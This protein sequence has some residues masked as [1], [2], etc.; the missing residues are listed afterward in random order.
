M[1][2]P[3]RILRPHDSNACLAVIAS[4]FKRGQVALVGWTLVAWTL[5]ATISVAQTPA[6]TS[7]SAPVD[8][9]TP[10]IITRQLKSL[11]WDFSRTDDANFNNRPDNWKRYE[12]IGYPS[13]VGWTIAARD[14]ALEKQMLGIDASLV[15]QWQAW[16]PT[17]AWL[18]LPPSVTDA[19][20]DRYLRIDLDGGQFKAQSPTSSASRLYQYRF[21]AD[22]MTSGLRHDLARA[23]LVFLDSAGNELVAHSSPRI[24]GTTE[25]TAVEIPL[26][27]P[28]MGTAAMMVRVVV[29]RSLDGLEDIRGTIGFDNLRIDQYPQLQVS[30]DEVRGVY[31]VGRPIVA[32]AKL[33]GLPEGASTVLFSLR[34]HNDRELKREVLAVSH[35]P[36]DADASILTTGPTRLQDKRASANESDGGA[37][38]NLNSEVSWSLRPLP[39]GFYRVAASIHGEQTSMLATDAS[40]VVIDD[41]AGRQPHG[42]F[43]WTLP[44]AAGSI[45]P[46]E[47]GQWLADLGVAWVK[48]PCW[49]EPDDTVG[50]EE[51]AATMTKLQESGIQTIGMLGV[52]P[53]SVIPKFELRGR[54][55]LVASQLFRDLPTWQ[56]LLEPIMTRLTLKV[57]TWQLGVDE[58]HS[59]LGRPRLRESIEQI[60]V[61]LQGFGQPIDVAISWPWSEEELDH[62]EASWQAVCRSS[63]PPLSADELDAFLSIGESRLRSSDGPRTWLLVDPID[64]KTY[65]RDAR[66]TDL[67]LRMATVRS[68]RVQAA[69][70]TNPFDESTGLLRPSG[71]P[72]ELLLPWRTTSRLIGNLRKTGSLQLPSGVS[73]TV[74]VGDDRAVL[75]MWSSEPREEKL[76]L[77]EDVQMVD[78]W[79]NVSSLPIEPDPVQ[80]GQR[81]AVGPVPVFITGA[82]PSLL[83]FRMSVTLQPDRLDSLLGQV[84]PL[85]VTFKNPSRDSLV[86]NVRLISP[87]SWT[88]NSPVRD[89]EM[90]P[91]RSGTQSFDIVLSNTA[92][93]GRYNVPLQFEL[94][95]VPPKLITVYR[96]VTVGPDGLELKITTRLLPSG[97]L[98]V[99][100][101][102]S[103]RSGK[104]Q[105]YD[106][107]LF[108][109][110]GR[111]YQ[112]RFVTIA[113][114]DTTRQDIYWPG[115]ADL[116]GQRML[117]R[118]IEEDGDRILNYPIDVQR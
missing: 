19:A 1:D 44:N 64:K 52:P 77:G 20:T 10:T 113:P 4:F 63:K 30:T 98:R 2:R 102:M 72:G 6:P 16:K 28:P 5:I 34:D 94:E 90:L 50:A 99:Q 107:F 81:I 117:L 67:V 62:D 48:Y 21:V 104:P 93:V 89:W 15:K 25:W 51:I 32:T 24:G 79:G 103:N 11:V 58:D 105:A 29:D 111:Q 108:P 59:F 118:A 116:I 33:M 80:P 92:Q 112:R 84:Q 56:P 12:G 66:I 86:G 106:Y 55:D 46:R 114:G 110:P 22:I 43:G 75:M 69:F 8:D 54:R 31:R 14:P 38:L 35:R 82:D 9:A 73:N 65:D 17:F 47:L 60:A 87:P 88:T 36:E 45:P 100:I 101:E 37:A 40:F 91:G 42:P 13:Y 23:E 57:R 27:R 74:F 85:S 68:H 39:P 95:T 49:L 97:D 76:Y 18:P 83:A 70:V 3:R 7:T 109:P 96:Q 115:G 71:R 53:D 26:I 78:V 41:I 61:G